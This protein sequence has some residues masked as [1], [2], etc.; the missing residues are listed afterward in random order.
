MT[1][2]WAAQASALAVGLGVGC[3]V[4]T[5]APVIDSRWLF[6]VHST[7]IGVE[8]LLPDSVSIDDGAFAV[9]ATP[10]AAS[11]D[12][13]GLCPDCRTG[14]GGS[15]P[16]PAFSGSF[17]ARASLPS[18][19]SS[20]EVASGTVQLELVHNFGFDPIR[21]PGGAPGSLVATLTEETGG[22]VV[23]RLELD[24]ATDSLPPD[25]SFSAML[26]L[27][28]GSIGGALSMRFEV[29]S[30]AGGTSAAHRVSIN[31]QNHV[32]ATATPMDVRLSSVRTDVLGRSASLEPAEVDVAGVDAGIVDRIQSG[33]LVLEFA[34]A[35]GAAMDAQLHIVQEA[36]TVVSKPFKVTDGPNS[37][38]SVELTADEFR[39]FLGKP[40]VMLAGSGV[41]TSPADG[42]SLT[43]VMEVRI[44]G[45]ID[46]VLRIGG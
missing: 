36:D 10:V 21:P 20:G 43:P 22:R 7:T 2:R 41:V 17:E 12:L 24:G 46:L 39:A 26:P 9:E 34:N 30:P 29:E 16:K 25:A 32:R 42:I 5:D 33:A 19:L 11:E 38:T 40:G 45:K 4:P 15:V 14:P 1:R 8:G 18:G 37:T 35:F 27:A 13:G 3:N 28:P 23:A 31:A 44:D 6:E